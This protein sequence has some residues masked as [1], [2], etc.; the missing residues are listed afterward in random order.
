MKIIR[1]IPPFVKVL[2]L[3]VV[4]IL[5]WQVVRTATAVTAIGAVLC[6]LLAVLWRKERVSDLYMAVAIVLVAATTCSLR[7]THTATIPYNTAIEAQATIVSL[8]T[9][10]A[11]W[12]QCRA[13]VVPQS[14]DIEPF[15]ALLGIDTALVAEVGMVSRLVTVPRPLPDNSYG[16]LMTR[17]GISARCYASTPDDWQPTALSHSPTI[18]ARR[19]QE[20]LLD[21][22]DA[23][24]ISGNEA[25]VCK[26]MAFGYRGQMSSELRSAYSRSGCAHLLAISGLHVGIVAALVWM[27]L[28]PL[29]L[30]WCRG[31]IVRNLMAMVAMVVYAILTGLA[32]SVVRATIMFCTVQASLAWGTTRTAT[33]TLAGALAVMLVA[34]PNNLFDISF[35]LSAVAVVGIAIGFQPLMQRLRCRWEVVNT[36]WALIVVA[37][38]STL[39]TLP[40]VAHTFGTVS[41]MGVV[42]SPVVIAL[43]HI[44]VL[45]SIVWSIA[46]IAPLAG[47]V[48]WIIG[49]AA[50]VQNSLVGS[51]SQLDW[52]AIEVRPEGWVVALC[53]LLMAAV[54]I[55]SETIKEKKEWKITF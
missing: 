9:T 5:L 12:Q 3:V 45:G 27:L 54:V 4:G 19:A 10:S 39:A 20:G 6:L 38:C 2:P 36:V 18:A 46:P 33:N 28:W 13:K 26:A 17:R 24:G 52:A 49:G 34:N 55:V 30:L 22:F 1:T 48:R 47:A 14:G 44:V 31:H 53:Y 51:V 25:A 23:L 41:L 40:I 32:P 11:R 29:P 35:Q 42:L 43:S 16:H 8:P 50:E 15:V 7:T 21:R 37:L